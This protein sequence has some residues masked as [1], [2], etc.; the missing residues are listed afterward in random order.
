MKDPSLWKVVQEEAEAAFETNPDTGKRELDIQ[1]MLALPL[2]QSVYVETLRLH[3]S[4]NITREVIAETTT[5]AGY[6]L[7]KHA[8][9]QAPTRIAHYE[10]RA[11]GI[12]DHPATEFWAFRNFKS[13][14]VQQGGKD[15]QK[16]EF[17]MRAGPNDFFPYGK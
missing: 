11:W 15:T 9:V 4:V 13:S 16:S 6:Q 7:P 3:V 14:A 10:E 2:L 5:M 8:L 12:D 1:K 17:A